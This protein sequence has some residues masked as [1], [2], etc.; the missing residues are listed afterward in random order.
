MVVF[1]FLDQGPLCPLHLGW[2]T[3]F[4]QA[5][6]LNDCV[7][8]SAEKALERRIRYPRVH[9]R[10]LPQA[11]GERCHRHKVG[12]D[13]VSARL[14]DSLWLC[15]VLPCVPCPLRTEIYPGHL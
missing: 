2:L 15:G 11:D 4:S 9:G 3:A 1:L 8:A 7:L 12:R 6:T 10:A 14:L 13:V 5:P